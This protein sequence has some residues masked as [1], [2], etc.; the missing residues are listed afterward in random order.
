[1]FCE[2]LQLLK[3]ALEEKAGNAIR[4]RQ[5]CYAK[6]RECFGLSANLA[7]SNSAC[8]SQ[9]DEIERKAIIQVKLAAIVYI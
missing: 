4:L 9:D 7:V 3:I 6:I 8:G 2:C 5:L 1:M